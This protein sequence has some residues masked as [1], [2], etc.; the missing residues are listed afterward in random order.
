M[1][2]ISVKAIIA[3]MMGKFSGASKG[4][5]GSMHYYKEENGF[6][7]GGG[8]VGDQVSCAVGLAFAQKYKGE[9]N[10]T[11]TQFGD[12]ATN[13]GQVYE[14]MNMALLWNLPVIYLLENNG[15]AMGTAMK[16]HSCNTDYYKRY[17]K[18][19]GV[20]VDGY[21]VFAMREIMKW[22]KKFSLKN[23][24]L[25]I[26][27]TTYRYHGHSMSDPGISYRSR[28][29]IMNVRRNL[30]CILQ[31]KMMMLKHGLIRQNQLK[32]MER[33]VKMTVDTAIREA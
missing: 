28:A 5:G 19:P 16:R 33:E 8:I 12:G 2:G 1:R 26:E 20:K 18:V 25:F 27:A 11:L 23:G 9:K 24:P 17:D 7:G 32:G 21:N 30:D 4:K 3:E 22:A 29:E 31:M 13:Q 15:Y 6:Y 14:G 10:I